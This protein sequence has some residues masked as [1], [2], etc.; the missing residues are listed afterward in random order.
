MRGYYRFRHH[1]LEELRGIHLKER[2]RSWEASFKGTGGKW[3][4]RRALA[5]GQRRKREMW[6]LYNRLSSVVPLDV[7]YIY[8]A[9]HFQ[10][11]RTTSSLGGVFGDQFLLVD[12]LA[13]SI[14]PGWRVYVKEHPSQFYPPFGGE[15]CRHADFYRDLQSCP[16]VHLV[17]LKMS[18]FELLDHSRA[19]ATV[20]G[21]AGF[22]AV[23]RGKPALI[24][25]SAW[26]RYCEGVFYV[27]T[28]DGLRHALDVIEAGYHVDPAHVQ[29]YM[30]V[31]DEF[32]AR[33]GLGYG[34]PDEKELEISFEENVDRL[35]AVV[36]RLWR[37]MDGGPSL[38][39]GPEM[40]LTSRRS[41]NG[42]EARAS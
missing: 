8:V 35:T 42:A 25:G 28:E 37:R 26:Y 27:P 10:P 20:T 14:P 17:S 19:V 16:N 24:T 40:G 36:E 15:R 2:G 12:L 5:A 1:Y 7:P 23:V 13:R 33:A 6:R 4:Y 22:E 32:C 29:I 21:T 30:R 38:S 31:F 39:S 34:T 11:E 3:R 41:P 9:L 18:T